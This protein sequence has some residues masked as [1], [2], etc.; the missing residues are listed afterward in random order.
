MKSIK[1]AKETL[2]VLTAQETQ[3]VGGAVASAGP[4]GCVFPTQLPKD[5]HSVPVTRCLPR[6][7][8]I[9]Q[10]CDPN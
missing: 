5:C 6:H 1:L 2:R 3:A 8:E 4:P 7:T 9:R 10:V